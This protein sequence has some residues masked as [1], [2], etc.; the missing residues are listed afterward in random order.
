MPVLPDAEIALAGRGVR[1]LPDV[2]ANSGTNAWW[3]QVTFGDVDGS[4]EQS[5]AYTAASI[6]ALVNEMV[7]EPAST[8]REAV[9]A[10]A[11]RRLADIERR[12]SGAGRVESVLATL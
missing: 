11:A 2:L 5:F 4:P 3:W 10:I 6:R 1:V 9:A 7:R 8:W 12:F